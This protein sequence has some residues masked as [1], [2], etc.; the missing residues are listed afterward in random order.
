MGELVSRYTKRREEVYY[1]HS[2]ILALAEPQR[3]FSGIMM[4]NILDN[5]AVSSTISK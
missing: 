3:L 1:I 2:G 5:N 4:Y